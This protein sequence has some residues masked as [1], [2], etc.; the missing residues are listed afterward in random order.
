MAFRERWP[1]FGISSVLHLLGWG[2]LISI[3]LP[4]QRDTAPAS[5]Y[6][7]VML[8]KETRRQDRVIWYERK[9][10]VPDITPRQRF[11]PAPTPRGRK[12]G[13]V[14]ISVTPKA[15]SGRQIIRQPSPVPIPKDVPAPNLLVLP[16]EQLPA[17][18]PVHRKFTPPPPV[19]SVTRQQR[20][21]EVGAPPALEISKMPFRNDLGALLPAPKLIRKTFV[22]PAA[23]A[24]GSRAANAGPAIPDSGPPAFARAQ[25]STASGL[26][27]VMVGL[28]PAT[29]SPPQGSR[30]G[31][32]AR[33]PVTGTP[34]SGIAPAGTAIVPDLVA[35]GKITEPTSVTAHAPIDRTVFREI[36]LPGVNRTMSAPLRPSSR[37]IPVS[38]EARFSNRNVYTLVIPGPGLPGYTGDWVMWFSER[39]PGQ[40][41]G[42]RILAPI[43][44]RK[45]SRVDSTTSTAPAVKADFQFAAIID[46]SGLLASPVVLRGPDALRRMALEEL[47]T[48]GFKPALRNGDPIDVDIVLEIPFQLPAAVQSAP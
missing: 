14:L 25:T 39:Q 37:I 23:S 46:R 8:P 20:L 35:R 12:V 47:E 48:W 38:V 1:A 5:H 21:L 2:L 22:P 32:F 34:S 27:A 30:S 41:A 45:Y 7:V 16:A 4:V 9:Q 11:G 3:Q 24:K 13:P 29:V 42:S 18:K 31:Q 15:M 6:T 44:S 10:S 19:R 26:E 40:D 17:P 43:P 33:A 36:T 28:S